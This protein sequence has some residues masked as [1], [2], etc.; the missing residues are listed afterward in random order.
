MVRGFFPLDRTLKLRADHRSDGAAE[1]ATRMAMRETSFARAAEE[2]QVAVGA[3]F[4]CTT[5]W[6]VT[7]GAGAI[8]AERKKAEA[9]RAV[10]V[11]ERGE[12]PQE[13]RIVEDQPIAGRAN[14]SSDGTMLLI[15]DEGW[16][17]IKMSAVS[18]VS[19]SEAIAPAMEPSAPTSD[20]PRVTAGARAIL[21]E[22]TKVKAERGVT[23]PEQGG[24]LRQQRGVED[25]PIPGPATI[26]SVGT[27]MAIRDDG[28]KEMRPRS[29]STVS[30]WGASARPVGPVLRRSDA[31]REHESR[32]RLSQHSYVAGLWE[33]DEFLKYQYAEGLRR[34]LDRAHILS[35]V[36]DAA[37]WIERVTATNFP[38]AVQIVDWSHGSQHLH[39]VAN[40]V[41]GKGSRAA[42]AWVEPRKDD[43]WAGAV[44]QVIQSLH[45]LGLT[46]KCWPAEVSQAPG[47]F[48]TNRDRMRYSE[49]RAAGYPIGSGTVESGGNNVVH[50]RMRR[51]GQGWARAHVNG[52]L[53]L[54]CEYHSGRFPRTWASL[55]RPAA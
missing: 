37:A 36:N 44:D 32:V 23:V 7:T 1:V 35:S 2:Y 53:A 43:L 14:L 19:V 28:Q 22:C 8:L 21:V 30:L 40:E 33:A 49:F 45:H 10:A 12:S 20:A 11:P 26:G 18:A 4:P 13:R 42:R 50:L 3:P 34:G 29:I 48:E 46:D 54:L 15:R 16:K 5:T 55:S 24:G 6:R 38:E 9:E 31:Q 27:M 52:M 39:S 41:F 17:E 47:Y 51:P 25:Q